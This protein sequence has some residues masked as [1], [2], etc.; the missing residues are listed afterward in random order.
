M[1]IVAPCVLQRVA[2]QPETTGALLQPL[3]AV[4]FL[5]SASQKGVVVNLAMYVLQPVRRIVENCVP[6]VDYAMYPMDV[7]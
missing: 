6:R 4:H 3:I 7:A 5:V 2:A 1:P